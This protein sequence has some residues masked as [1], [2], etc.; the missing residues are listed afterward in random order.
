LCGVGNLSHAFQSVPRDLRQSEE[1]LTGLKEA[2]PARVVTNDIA[3]QL[4]F[5]G[6]AETYPGVSRFILASLGSQTRWRRHL[7]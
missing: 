2:G 7:P 1:T 3:G 6:D 5:F 4:A